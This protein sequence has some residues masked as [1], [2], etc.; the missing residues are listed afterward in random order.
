MITIKILSILMVLVGAICLS[1]SFAPSRKIW[2]KVTG[3][4]R[5]K[6]LIIIYLMGFFLL[7]YVFFD[8]VL[9]SHLSFPVELVTAG[10][11][12]GGAVFVYLIINISQ[13]TIAE[14]QK[15]EEE[16]KVLN[17][18][19]ERR[20]A[21]RTQALR[22]SEENNRLLLQAA[23]DG[24]FGVNTEGQ[25]TFVN[26]AALRMLGFTAEEM[27]GQGVHA[28]IHHSRKD[29]SS[30]PPEDCPMYASYT[31][32]TASNVIDEFL[33]RKDGS[34]FPVEYS[35]TPV[36]KDGKISGAVVIFQDVTARKRSEE[37]TSELQSLS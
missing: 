11:F 27:L 36:I 5:R 28:L 32:A 7:G 17:E 31:N 33:W 26:S 23:G 25:V 30:Y 24:I 35:S 22:E 9:I 8:I 15:A 13:S 14:R 2:E 1:L 19:L 18:S 16:I 10:V 3:P 34:N 20:V 21:D 12:L 37:H 4:L 29:G 6:W